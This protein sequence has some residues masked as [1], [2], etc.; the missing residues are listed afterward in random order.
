MNMIAMKM[1]SAS[2]LAVFAGV[3]QADVRLPAIISDNMVLQQS[4]Q[5]AVWGKADPGE[6][7]R[8]Q[9]NGQTAE[10]TT[11][12]QGT[13]RLNLDLSRQPQGPFDML[14]QGKN[15]LTIH[16]VLVGQVWLC[17]GQ[18]NMEMGVGNAADAQQEAAAANYPGIR[19][20]LV[21]HAVADEPQEEIDA[22]WV[23]CTP[24][25]VLAT[26]LPRW[27]GFSAAAYFFGREIHQ[28]LNVPV[29]LIESAWGGTPAEAWTS[30][31]VL[32]ADRDFK[33]FFE[34][35]EEALKNYPVKVSK[36]PE[37]LAAWQR[38]A[39]E[40]KTAGRQPTTQPKV[41]TDPRK[42]QFVASHLYNGMLT[43][44]IPYTIAGTVWYQ[45]EANAGRAYQYRRL[46]PVM[47]QDWR[48]RWGQG[49]FPF[50]FVQL[51]NYRDRANQPAES[52]WA[53]LRE[54]QA[55]TLSLPK[56]AMAVTIDI[57]DAKDIHPKNKQEVGRRLA[58]GALAIAYSK[59][60]EHSGPAFASM[61]VEGRSIRLTFTHTAGGLVAKGEKLTGFAIAGVDRKFVWA[62]A[63]IDG[64]T[65][66]V[67]SDLI[68]APTAVRYAW[69]NN[70][71][72]NLYNKANLPASPF[73][74]DD[75]PGIT[76]P[77]APKDKTTN[78]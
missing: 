69:A 15:T 25:S 45:G 14:V 30:R 11:G 47:I 49:D 19:L 71:D 34:T 44:L 13:W 2:L 40:A 59:D 35:Y 31:E 77:V 74:T 12:Q 75:W 36:Y 10:T 73:R 48:T 72:C 16:N 29:G 33:S 38:S 50:I 78:P 7:V 18:S 53:E 20:F 24:Q 32:L 22:K 55:M 37:Q 8:V 42:S 52:D 54:A 41:P 43:P 60:I 63:T 39:D 28:R 46:F 17:S 67:H 56:T 9:L 76:A 23:V 26:G 66:L 65:I 4:S 1:I 21:P 70:P 5:V 27:G 57:G 62:D 61:T 58:L 6:K 68:A 64:D 3:A 51:A